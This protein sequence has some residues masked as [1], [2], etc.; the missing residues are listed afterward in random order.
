MLDKGHREVCSTHIDGCKEFFVVYIVCVY[1]KYY[2]LASY[3]VR[4]NRDFIFGEM[5]YGYVL[6]AKRPTT[7]LFLQ[8]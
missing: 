3:Y 1:I 4:L 5:I 6:R 8:W 7:T 2:I